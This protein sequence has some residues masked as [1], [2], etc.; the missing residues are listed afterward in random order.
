M[1]VSKFLYICTR[2]LTNISWKLPQSISVTPLWRRN[3]AACRAEVLLIMQNPN[4]A[5]VVLIWAAAG[6]PMLSELPNPSA[7]KVLFTEWIFRMACLKLQTAMQENWESPMSA[8]S[9]L[10]WKEETFIQ[11]SQI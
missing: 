4:R 8:S 3:H 2:L 5:N 7:P 11:M 9:N 10:I 1:H 6:E